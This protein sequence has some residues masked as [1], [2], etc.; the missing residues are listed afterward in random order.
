MATITSYHYTGVGAEP[1]AQEYLN[2]KLL[3]QLDQIACY[4]IWNEFSFFSFNKWGE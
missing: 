1:S 3:I 2:K 4:Q